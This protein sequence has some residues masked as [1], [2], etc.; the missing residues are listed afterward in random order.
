MSTLIRN[1]DGL[2]VIGTE[3]DPDSTGPLAASVTTLGYNSFGDM[4]HMIAA[5]GGVTVSTYSSTLH[6]QLSSTDPVG[7]TQ[8]W[9]YDANGNMTTSTD[10]GGFVTTI[11]CAV[12]RSWFR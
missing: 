8:S 9:A 5:D 12:L 7:R 6:Q 1:A 11:A 3:P 4:T 2:P 10:G